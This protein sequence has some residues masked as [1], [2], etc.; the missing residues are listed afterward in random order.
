MQANFVSSG[1]KIV[2][3]IR[4]RKND[5]LIIERTIGLVLGPSTALYISFLKSR[6]HQKS[7]QPRYLSLLKNGR[8]GNERALIGETVCWSEIQQCP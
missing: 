3:C 2:K 6:S 1:S 8:I 4:C 5:L 7:D